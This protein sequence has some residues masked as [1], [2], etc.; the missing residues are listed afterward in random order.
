[1]TEAT[2]TRT[3]AILLDQYHGAF[4][5]AIAEIVA[6]LD[7][8]DLSTARQHLDQLAMLAPVGRH[9]TTPWRVV[10]AGAA[11]VGKSSLV[12]A[13]AGFQRSV[14]SPTPGTT[15]DV[16]TVRLAVDGWPVELVDT[17]GLRGEASGL[18]MEGIDRARMALTEADLVLW[19]LDGSTAPIMPLLP[20][21]RAQLVRNKSDLPSPWGR[22]AAPTAMA[23]SARTGEG[24]GELTSALAN[25][26]VPE[27]PPAGSAVPFTPTLADRV[28]RARQHLAAGQTAEARRE[29]I[30]ASG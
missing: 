5:R 9:L 21:A 2:T 17:A 11:N 30:A 24:L 23:V 7:V 4:D 3:A 29:L 12:N 13:L 16:V 1:L 14:V 19:V 22:E 28:E 10:V 25:W 20:H 26:L 15:R 6:A 18:E 8:G 27:S